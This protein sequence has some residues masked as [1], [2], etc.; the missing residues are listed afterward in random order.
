MVSCPAGDVWYMMALPAVM[1]KLL[2]PSMRFAKY[3]QPIGLGLSQRKVTS[4]PLSQLVCVKFDAVSVIVG[5]MAV[6]H[7]MMDKSLKC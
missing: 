3:T 7:D 1:R 4:A 5:T 6:A 2:P